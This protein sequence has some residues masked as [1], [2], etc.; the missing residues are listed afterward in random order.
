MTDQTQGGVSP[1][2]VLKRVPVSS[3]TRTI[4]EQ[5]EEMILTGQLKVGEKL[6]SEQ[7]LANQSGVGRRAIREALK[8][9][10]LKGLITVRKGSGAFVVRNDFDNYI[11]TL[12]RNVQAYLQVD[13]VSIVHILQ[14]RELLAGSVIGI[15][16]TRADES[17]FAEMESALQKQELGLQKRSPSLYTRAHIDYHFAIITSLKNPVVTRMYSEIMRLLEPYMKRSAGNME[18]VQQSI[19]EH[20][21]IL[22]SIKAG[23][24]ARAHSAFHNH[25][26]SSLEHLRSVVEQNSDNQ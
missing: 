23:D 19:A 7:Q 6:P 3:V 12:S 15:L 8:A 17:T 25:L 10:E 11:E 5:L 21:E 20:R 14:F 22:E 1:R 9:L 4:A 16:A 2:A 26:E 18:I 24:T 13:Q